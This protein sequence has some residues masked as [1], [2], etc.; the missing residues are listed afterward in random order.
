MYIGI[1]VIILAHQVNLSALMFIALWRRWHFIDAEFRQNK[2]YKENHK[3]FTKIQRQRY[4]LRCDGVCDIVGW[5]KMYLG[6]CEGEY[7]SSV[8]RVYDGGDFKH[9]GIHRIC[10][11]YTREEGKN[12]GIWVWVPQRNRGKQGLYECECVLVLVLMGVQ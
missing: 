1:R 3:I 8:G 11:H 12:I 10:Y 7:C 4:C 5:P 2:L 9:F 6:K